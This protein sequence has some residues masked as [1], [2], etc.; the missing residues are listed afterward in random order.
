[1]AERAPIEALR[2]TAARIAS[3]QVREMAT[4][5][6]NL[7][8]RNRCWFF[9]SGFDC[10]KRGGPTCPC[11]AVNGDHRFY[12]AVAHAHR[13][14][15]V[16]PSDLATTLTALDATLTISGPNGRRSVPIGDFFTGPGETVLKRDELLTAVILP[17]AAC[18]RPAR[19][20][21]LNLWEGDFAVASACASL[22]VADDGTVEDA[23]L[24]LGAVA[25]T[26]LRLERLERRLVGIRIDAADE[27]A[28]LCDSWASQAHPLARNEWKVDAASALLRR[29]IEGCGDAGSPQ[30]ALS[31]AGI[32]N[33]G[34]PF[35]RGGEQ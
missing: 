6:G 34:P 20:E 24:V 19:F 27:L 17:P 30:A 3:P 28:A 22:S 23:S 8:Q 33:G 21:K 1:L 29:S 9:R 12:H 7:C 13:C 2:E 25:P 31:G 26:P 14:Q 15:A 4:V 5:A 35:P 11:Y 18:R 32:G 16:T 10:Y